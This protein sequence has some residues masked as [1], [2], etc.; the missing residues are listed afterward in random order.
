MDGSCKSSRD[1]TF[2]SVCT[3][4]ERRTKTASA[5]LTLPSLFK[6]PRLITNASF[7]CFSPEK[8]SSTPKPAT[9]NNCREFLD[10][11]LQVRWATRGDQ[12]EIT[13]SAKMR[14]DQYVAFGLSGADDRPQ[15]V[16]KCFEENYCFD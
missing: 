13:L 15:M 2:Q 9:P 14:E 5:Q 4:S 10:R 6:T 8:T 16:S 12:V 1:I 3:C 7:C 11:R